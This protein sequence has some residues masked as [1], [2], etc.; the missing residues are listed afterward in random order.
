MRNG[1]SSGCSSSCRYHGDNFWHNIRIVV[2][3]D[4][5]LSAI[6]LNYF[7][8]VIN[9]ISCILVT[10]TS[11]TN[12]NSIRDTNN[13]YCS[14]F[15]L[16]WRSTALLCTIVFQIGLCVVEGCVG[17]SIVWC[18]LAGWL[19][20]EYT[21]A[22]S[23][24]SSSSSNSIATE[25]ENGHTASLVHNHQN[26]N[27]VGDFDD[28]SASTT[29]SI[30]PLNATRER[31]NDFEISNATDC[32][33]REGSMENEEHDADDISPPQQSTSILS[34][35]EPARSSACNL[36]SAADNIVPALL[37]LN[38]AVIVYYF[39]TLPFITTV[40]H[41]CALLLGVLISKTEKFL[42]VR[43]RLWCS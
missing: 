3:Y 19:W 9:L 34:S 16:G 2:T 29:S 42:L 11:H 32:Y 31:T 21:Q 12:N 30:A 13:C 23:S 40:A 17:I 38:G 27:V 39:V 26:S 7:L 24:S 10:T 20:Q 4:G 28:V 14:V 15:R 33:V 35:S 22:H 25:Q 36:W 8:L 6:P 37:V 5:W 41:M 43:L 1:A 18:A